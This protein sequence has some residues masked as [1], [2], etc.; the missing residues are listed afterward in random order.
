MKTTDNELYDSNIF[1]KI[2]INFVILK[3]ECIGGYDR[4]VVF[5][6]YFFLNKNY[7]RKPKKKKCVQFFL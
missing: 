2:K 5:S 6:I 3:C 4:E 7:F 1:Y